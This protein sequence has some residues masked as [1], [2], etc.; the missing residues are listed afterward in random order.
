MNNISKGQ[1]LDIAD[2]IMA[3]IDYHVYDL[4]PKLKDVL[5]NDVRRLRNYGNI[6]N[7][8]PLGFVMIERLKDC[9]YL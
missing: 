3:D 1:A 7:S 5:I 2:V 6:I 9:G 4:Y 8:A